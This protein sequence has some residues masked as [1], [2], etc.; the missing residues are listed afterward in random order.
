MEV[1]SNQKIHEERFNVRKLSPDRSSPSQEDEEGNE[2]KAIKGQK[3][4][5]LPSKEEWDNHMRCH[6]P[7]RRWC[8]F[9]VKGRSKSGAHTKTEKSEEE[10]EREV[11][12]IAIDYM[13]PRSAEGKVEMVESLPII[14]A[15]DRKVKWHAAIMVPQKGINGYAVRAVAREIELSGYN[16][17]ILKSDQ[18][19]AILNLLRAVKRE[20]EQK[21]W[22]SCQRN[23]QWESTRA[24]G[25][26]RGQCN[27]LK[28]KSNR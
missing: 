9:C 18:E 2:G 12:V 10:K 14:V 8:P 5:N 22:K 4:I 19:P 11:P 3:R 23:P 13:E 20:R 25:M 21:M 7:F 24:M 15:I 28:G 16:R 17:M 1:K 27:R 26:W 6:I